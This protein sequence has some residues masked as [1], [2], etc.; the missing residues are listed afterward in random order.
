MASWAG[1]VKFLLYFL[2]FLFLG[3]I[4]KKEQSIFPHSGL[5]KYVKS[6]ELAEIS[7]RTQ[8]GK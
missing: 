6:K 2:C 7:E 4:M 5:L 1:A 8:G 3:K